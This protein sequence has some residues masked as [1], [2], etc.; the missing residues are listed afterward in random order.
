MKFP[1][2]HL[3]G[4]HPD[5]LLAGYLESMDKLYEAIQALQKACPNARDYVG[6]PTTWAH[7][8]AA[9]AQEH[10]SRVARVIEVRQEIESIIGNIQEQVEMRERRKK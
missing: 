1:M 3:G 9:A 8:F 4:T 7:T 10:Q 6:S 2:V 5:D